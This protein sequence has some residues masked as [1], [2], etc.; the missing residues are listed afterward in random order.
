MNLSEISL[1]IH[2]QLFTVDSARPFHFAALNRIFS[3]HFLALSIN[4]YYHLFF[5]L[6]R[7]NTITVPSFDCRTWFQT[8]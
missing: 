5:S 1:I 6:V 8:L 4:F 7:H 2:S 3:Y